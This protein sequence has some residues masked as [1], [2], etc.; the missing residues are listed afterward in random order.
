MQE[1]AL[2]GST[3]RVAEQEWASTIVATCEERG[4][5]T[6]IEHAQPLSL[7]EEERPRIVVHITHSLIPG[8]MPNTRTTTPLANSKSLEGST[9]F[10][11][12][13]RASGDEQLTIG[14]ATGSHLR[15]HGKHASDRYRGLACAATTHKQYT[16]WLRHCLDQLVFK[17]VRNHWQL[18]YVRM[19]CL[20]LPLPA[21][22]CLCF[23][24][25]RRD[26][27]RNVECF[28]D[29]MHGVRGQRVEFDHVVVLL[30]VIGRQ[31]WGVALNDCI[32]PVRRPCLRSSQRRKRYRV[33]PVH[34]GALDPVSRQEMPRNAAAEV[35]ARWA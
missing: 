11:A 7:S 23:L 33:V 10:I 15:V 20:G 32:L 16:L 4:R 34:G 14:I 19:C 2:A 9:D 24:P 1:A 22:P 28:H 6:C 29:R 3:A 25:L 12:Q 27:P 18:C 21:L 8:L 17:L 30:A 26:G 5:Q 13:N 31:G 35:P